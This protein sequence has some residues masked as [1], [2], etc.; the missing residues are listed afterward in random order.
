MRLGRKLFVEGHAGVGC[1]D[2]DVDNVPEQLD[3]LT[4]V[5]IQCI[6]VSLL[7]QKGSLS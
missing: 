2:K 3:L 7:I 6:A 1:Y 5:D 4:N